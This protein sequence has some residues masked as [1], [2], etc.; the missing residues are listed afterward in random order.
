MNKYAKIAVL[1]TPDNKENPQIGEFHFEW[2]AF[3][4]VTG[5]KNIPNYKLVSMRNTY[6]SAKSARRAAI[7]AC[8]DMG[9][10]VLNKLEKESHH[11]QKRSYKRN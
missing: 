7:K 2:K 3:M 5:S 11:V 10:K 8:E 4:M 9:Y 1:K 6:Q